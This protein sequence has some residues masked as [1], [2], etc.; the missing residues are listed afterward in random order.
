MTLSIVQAQTE[1]GFP[2]NL[3]LVLGG[4]AAACVLSYLLTYGVIFFCR[5]FG[6]LDRSTVERTRIHT[7]PTPRLGGVAMFLAF[8]IAALLFYVTYPGVQPEEKIR[9][10][11]LLAASTLIVAVHAYDDVRGLK[12]LT[13]LI[14]QTLAVIIILGPW[15]WHFYGVILFGFSNPFG[16]VN[17]PPGQDLPWYRDSIISIFIHSPDITWLAIPAVLV[18]WFWIAG[19]MNT[20]N[21]IDGLDGLAGGVVAITGIFIC[22]I[23]WQL[24]QYTICTLSAIFTGA[25]LGF[26]PHNWNPAKVF[27]GDSG[28]QFLGIMLAVLSVMGGAKV[29][30][31]LMVLGIPILDVAIVIVGRLRKGVSAAQHDTSSHLHYRLLATGLNPKQICFIFY[32]LTIMFGVLA[33]SLPRPLKIGGLI[34]VGITMTV[35]VFWL[36]SLKRKRLQQ[37]PK[38]KTAGTSAV[39]R[40]REQS[41]SA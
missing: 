27:M 37:G 40:K 9:F 3:F 22:I 30:L 31:A 5:K 11:L 34:L 28:S 10:W 39:E 6:L 8:V 13:K 33:L 16:V 15:N 1:L 17:P 19:M 7:T 29:A 12:P 24:K 18:T 14:F 21:F 20:V 2:A 41:H 32:G 38:E 36:E 25:V 35:L 23:C 4:A 26:L